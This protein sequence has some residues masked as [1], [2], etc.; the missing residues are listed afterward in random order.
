MVNYSI[1]YW[2]TTYHFSNLFRIKQYFINILEIIKNTTIYKN[3]ISTSVMRT[4]ITQW[5]VTY[6]RAIFLCAVMLWLLFPVTLTRTYDLLTPFTIILMY[7]GTL[8]IAYNKLGSLKK[9]RKQTVRYYLMMMGIVPLLLFFALQGFST[10]IATGVLLLAWAPA[11]IAAIAFTRLMGGNTLLALCLAVITT[12][13]LPFTLPIL[14][15]YSVWASIELDTQWMIIDLILFCILPIIAAYITQRKS[16]KII[17]TIRPHIDRVSILMIAIMIAWPVAVNAEQFL[18][19]SLLKFVSIVW[20]LFVLSALLHTA[21]R[22]CFANTTKENQI[23]GS[24]AKWFMNISITT[25]LAAKY[26]SPEV[27]LIVILY[28]FPRDLM[29]IPFRWFVKKI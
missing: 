18:S 13:W 20:W 26:F 25:V 8:D 17:Q 5:I 9:Y 23:A 14:L 28:E 10:D 4:K 29:L 7:L 19:I 6:F 2:I 24:L 1:F 11:G 22:V 12:L 16:Q 21:W 27:L 3:F 15:Q